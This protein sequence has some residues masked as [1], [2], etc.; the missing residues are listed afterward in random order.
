M[1]LEIGKYYVHEGGRYIAVVGEVIT[2]RWGKMFVIEE[3]DVTGYSVSCTE[4]T[5]LNENWTEI[6]KDEWLHNFSP[7]GLQ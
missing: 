2:Y 7:G 4:A 3:A 5:E 6:G 1:K